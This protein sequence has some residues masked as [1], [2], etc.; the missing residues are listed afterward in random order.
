VDFRLSEEQQLLEG[1]VTDFVRNEYSFE[2]RRAIL[3]SADGFSRNIWE[4]LAEI[5]LLGVGIPEADGGV[6]AGPV[7]TMLVMNSI[8]TALVLE[9]YLAS[10]VVSAALLCDVDDPR[11]SRELLAAIAAGESIVVLAHEDVEARAM[12]AEPRGDGYVV[13]GSKA[14]VAHAQIAD[15]LIVSA[16]TPNNAT[17]L[18]R[19][20][21]ST[22]GL[23]L[24]EF[25]S[26]DG[27]LAAD[28][29]LEGVELPADALIGAEGEGDRPLRAGL[30]A[31]LAAVCAEAV[32]AMQA[33]IDLT[34]QYLKSRHQF[35]RPIGRFQA[36]QHRAADMM[37]HF[38][39]A[40]S[41]SYLAS[42]RC[43]EPASAE[44]QRALSAAKVIIGRACRFVGQQAIQ[45]HGG[46]GM[47]DE[48]SVSHYFR[49][50]TAIE[51]TFGDAESH[52]D[53]FRGP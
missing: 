40:R 19:V 29:S 49:R 47:T 14:V 48:L 27:Q 39:Q 18:L 43:A 1:M 21:G 2:K 25:R 22:P 8:G 10:A 34:C 44:R 33:L 15:T 28:V 16:L 7:A 45:L 30:D 38:E 4:Q 42:L 23:S 32:G 5:G 31:G 20:P 6:D 37:I 51:Q 46:M 53:R 24:R 3:D 41:M 17:S 50:L 26:L 35:G 9:P 11:H 12:R 13:T 36:L 52:I